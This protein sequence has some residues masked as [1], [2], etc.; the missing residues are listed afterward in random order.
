MR[1]NLDYVYDTKKEEIQREANNF[2]K[3]ASSNI[4]TLKNA[5]ILPVVNYND[6]DVS[7][8]R[9][10]VVDENGNYVEMSKT[11]ARVVGKYEIKN[12]ECKFID[13]KVVFCGY[14][15]RAWGHFI[16]E[17]VSRLWYALKNDATIDN[18]VFIIERNTQSDFKGNYL[19][20]LK[21][22]GI[23]E[24]TIILNEPTIFSEVIVPEEGFVYS[25]HYTQSFIEMYKYICDKA[26][27]MYSGPIYERVY[28][29]KVRLESS[30]TSNININSI[31]KYFR[32]NGFKIFYPEQ[33]NLIDM[34]GILQNAKEFA[35]ISSSL[36]HNHLFGSSNLKVIAIEKQAFYNPYQVFTA[37]IMNCETVFIDA[38]IN[39]FPVG[40][41]GP[42]L[43]DYTNF[44]KKY[45]KDNGM[46]PIKKMSK[47]KLRHAFKTY[48]I[49]YFNEHRTLPPDYMYKNYIL[50]IEREF[51]ESTIKDYKIFHMSL[52]QRIKVKARKILL[53]L[54]N[55]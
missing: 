45:T 29:S 17:S 49:Y 3:S 26:L 4:I 21:L 2:V 8:G 33:L 55:N 27:K 51:Y 48:M 32:I 38:C 41:F 14:F 30:I 31:D 54:R 19:E 36:L 7:A 11:K 15:N 25:D 52:Y 22:L 20:F 40:S 39:I 16:T 50:K 18:Y 44:L 24:K 37:K 43:F 42:F 23:S 12:D 28:F 1:F 47:L 13:K 34:I 10:G 9:G 5:K 35:G 53:R 6:Y 46:K